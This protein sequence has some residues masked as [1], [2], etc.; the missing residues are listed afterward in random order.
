MYWGAAKRY[1]REYCD[2]TWNRLQKTVPEALNFILLVEIRRF[3]Q[4]SWRYMDIYRK[5]L[6]KNLLYLQKKNINHIEGFLMMYLIR[7]F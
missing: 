6:Q 2:Y 5:V 4:K 3:A 1:T 7:L